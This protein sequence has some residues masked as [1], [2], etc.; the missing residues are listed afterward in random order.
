[1]RGVNREPVPRSTIFIAALLIGSVPLRAEVTGVDVAKLEPLRETG[2]PVIDLRT[3]KE[4]SDTG[5]IEG[6]RLLT[7]ADAR[8]HRD[9][10][11]WASRL[12]AIS[13]PEGAHRTHLQ[14]AATDNE[15]P[16]SSDASSATTS[17]SLSMEIGHS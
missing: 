11:G 16:S 10:D 9:V 7:F 6:S 5:V 12:A 17:C 2:V 1:M 8:R 15:P 3:P 13:G 14:S 4:W